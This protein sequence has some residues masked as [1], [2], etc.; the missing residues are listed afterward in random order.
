MIRTAL[1]LIKRRHLLLAAAVLLALAG[2]AVRLEWKD[3]AAKKRE[4]HY[5][6]SLAAYSRAFSPGVSRTVVE[7]YLRSND[8][9]FR[10]MCCIEER[11]AF[12]DLTKIG[13]ESHP[14]YCSAKNV[15]IAFEFAAAEP[16]EALLAYDSDALKKVSIFQWL[17]GCL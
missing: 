5:Q 1:S 10:Q 6:S 8:I 9:E 14:W 17:E 2:S 13:Q 11:S 3:Q 7:S 16:R 12:A 15:Y 4:A